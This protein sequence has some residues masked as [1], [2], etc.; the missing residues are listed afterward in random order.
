M[1]EIYVPLN[2]PFPPPLH[3]IALRT[4]KNLSDRPPPLQPEMGTRDA[5]LRDGPVRSLSTYGGNCF[6]QSKFRFPARSISDVWPLPH[7]KLDA[8]ASKLD[9]W[10]LTTGKRN[11]QPTSQGCGRKSA[12]LTLRFQSDFPVCLKYYSPCSAELLCPIST[13]FVAEEEKSLW[14]LSGS[15]FELELAI[16]LTFAIR[17]TSAGKPCKPRIRKRIRNSLNWMGGRVV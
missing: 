8:I 4:D 16:G 12:V 5:E 14:G 13:S 3:G 17:C 2:S 15:T 11:Q 10:T 1:P 6:A 7:E 9:D